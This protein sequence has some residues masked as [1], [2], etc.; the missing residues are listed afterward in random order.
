MWIDSHGGSA[1][2]T[3][4]GGF[5]QSGVGRGMGLVGLKSYTDPRVLCLPPAC[6]CPG[7]MLVYMAKKQRQPSKSTPNIASKPVPRTLN[8]IR[9]V[10]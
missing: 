10:Q 4:F 5:E 1:L 9:Q 7:C 6:A 8:L 2:E 3:R